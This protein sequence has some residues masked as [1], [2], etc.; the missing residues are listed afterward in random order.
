MCKGKLKTSLNN[1]NLAHVFH[2][3]CAGLELSGKKYL[4]PFRLALRID[5]KRKNLKLFNELDHLTHFGPMLHCF[6][7]ENKNVQN[8]LRFI[9]NSS[10]YYTRFLQVLSCSR[11]VHAYSGFLI[12]V[13]KFNLSET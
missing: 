1:K 12:L 6:T 13:E 2:F 10:K 8:H 3:N 9:I 5:S 11:L 7:S 4:Y